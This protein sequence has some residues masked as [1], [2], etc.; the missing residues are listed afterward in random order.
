MRAYSIACGI[1]LLCA[2]DGTAS[3][4]L[5]KSAFATNHCLALGGSTTGFAADLGYRVPVVH[6]VFWF[7]V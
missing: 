4:S 1:L 2:D 3:L 5:V 7:W 6:V